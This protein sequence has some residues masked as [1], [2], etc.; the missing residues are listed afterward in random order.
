MVMGPQ[1][2]QHLRQVKPLPTPDELAKMKKPTAI[3]DAR[4][5][6][7]I[8]NSPDTLGDEG[9]EF[10]TTTPAPQFE[11]DFQPFFSVAFS[12]IGLQGKPIVTILNDMRDLVERLLLTFE[13]RF[14]S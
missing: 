7:I 6:R 11:A 4:P 2:G 13:K 8:F 1:T 14:F 10:L 12:E 3:Y 9:L 5:G